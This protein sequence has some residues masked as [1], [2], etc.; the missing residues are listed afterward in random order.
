MRVRLGDPIDRSIYLYGVYEYRVAS[1]FSAAMRQG[2]TILD[3]GAH[4]GLYTLLAA[5]RVGARGRVMAVEPNPATAARLHEN[6]A[7]NGF[8]N[9]VVVQSALSDKGAEAPLFVPANR[10][11]RGQ[12]SLRPDW[13]RES[14]RTTITVAS[15]RLDA[16]LDRLR[17]HRLDVIK[18]DVEGYEGQALEGGEKA[19]TRDH[20]TILFEANDLRTRNGKTT[21]AAI[22]LLRDWGYQI[23]GIAMDGRGGCWLEMLSAGQDP[24]PYQEPWH[25]LNLVAIHP[26]RT[27]L[28]KVVPSSEVACG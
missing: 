10:D 8:Q 26:H 4:H 25:A 27:F 5:N 19:I 22:D 3:A 14:A 28:E 13:Q 16:V 7:L 20:P 11:L 24:R 21:S 1:V 2:M 23:H 6:I 12:A 17:C 15:E 9:V 18:L